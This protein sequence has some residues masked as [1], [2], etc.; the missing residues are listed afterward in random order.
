MLKTYLSVALA[1]VL[2]TSIASAEVDW[3]LLPYTPIS[4]YEAVNADGSSAY[5]GG[6]PVKLIGVVLNNTEDWLD[7]T[8]AYTDT[9][10]PWNLGG[11]A[12]VI[13]QAVDYN[14]IN[15]GDF[16]GVFN[17]MGQN[18]GNVPWHGDPSW[19]YTNAQW[20][21]ELGRL[22]LYGG[23]GV[24]EPVRAGDLVEIRARMGLNYSGKMNVNEAH[25]P[26]PANDFEIVVLQRNYGLPTPTALPLNLI[27]DAG[28]AAIFDPTRA[29][30]GEH[31]QA[32]LVDL[33]N[34]KVISGTWGVDQTVT[35][36]DA[37]GRTLDMYLGLNSGFASTQAPPGYFNA[38]GIIQQSSSSGKDGYSLLALDPSGVI[39]HGDANKDRKVSIQD[40]NV[41]LQNYTGFA[42]TGRTWA[43]GNFNEAENGSVDTYDF[44]ATIAN[45]TGNTPYG[46][47]DGTSGTSL[48]AMSLGSDEM[49]LAGGGSGP[50]SG[51]MQ[52]V[53]DIVT[54]QMKFVGNAA[55]VNNWDIWSPSG[56]LL[57]DADGNASPWG[58]YLINN[59]SEI[60]A[61]TGIG[62]FVTVDGDLLLDAAF[63]VGGTM[64][65]QFLYAGTDGNLVTGDVVTVPE[66]ATLAILALGGLGVIRR[67][68]A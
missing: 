47:S 32:T 42:G 41:V 27:K 26:S 11:Q 13:I 65:L 49:P 55:E 67:R 56:S 29:T 16:G 34:V 43:Q 14:G 68:R 3:S 2:T 10:Q 17:W 6:F 1:A 19:N 52:L 21:A 48:M 45:F 5:S 61:Y 63:H 62:S 35:V 60:A 44:N 59:S 40:F 23:D 24:T 4:T 25:D 66:P 30:G 54:G 9:Y 58:G 8:P 7:P 50:A 37:S 12:E 22:G 46:P 33:K 20:T 18:Y 36:Q 15:P 53:V 64:D 57:A 51:E 28:D 39:R 31:Y 38:E